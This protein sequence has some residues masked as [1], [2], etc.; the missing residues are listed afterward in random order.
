MKDQRPEGE[1]PDGGGDLVSRR[2]ALEVQLPQF[3]GP[4]DLLLHLV[5]SQDMDI[6]DIPVLVIARQYNE[7]LDRMLEL[8]LEIASEYLLMAASLAHIKSRLMLP[9]E[10]GDAGEPPEDPR[11]E[12]VGQLLAYEKFRKAAEGL[13]A[14]ESGRDLVF[15]RPG[16]PPPDL[17]G[18]F[19]IKAD[20]TDVVRAFERVVRQLEAEDRVE[21]IRREDF[22]V[23]DMMQR[24]LDRL[25]QGGPLSFRRLA[26]VCRTRL[27]RI[28]LFLALL[29]LVRIGSIVAWQS[30]PREDIRIDPRPVE[31]A[32]PRLS[33]FSDAPAGAEGSV[34]PAPEGLESAPGGP[35]DDAGDDA[36]AG[37]VDSAPDG[38]VSQP[39]TPPDSQPESQSE[40]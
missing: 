1:P 15:V 19:T 38:P 2:G 30:A 24:I 35:L 21:V 7:Y 34:E 33:G 17:A 40:A 20:L 27:E 36:P 39:D 28:V 26:G 5:R 3:E 29:E 11:E 12:L 4:L 37:L 22:K 13:A 23:Q 6:L 14:L 9:P 16:P 32:Q 31:S 18:Q 8:D 25:D 10:P